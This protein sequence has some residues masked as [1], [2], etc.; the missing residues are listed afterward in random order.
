MLEELDLSENK[1]DE[2]ASL[3]LQ[4]WISKIG[5][6]GSLSKLNL[7]KTGAS[8]GLVLPALENLTK[9]EELDISNS[10]LDLDTAQI[11]SR[12]ISGSSTFKKLDVSSCNLAPSSIS[13]IIAAIVKNVNLRQVSLNLSD[14]PIDDSNINLL[15]GAF[16]SSRVIE[17]LDLSRIKLGEKGILQLFD[18]IIRNV[19]SLKTLIIQ[20]FFGSISGHISGALVGHSLAD[21]ILQIPSIKKLDIST[22]KH[23]MFTSPPAHV[24]LPFL[25]RMQR[26]ETLLELVMTGNRLADKLAVT[27]AEMLR[28][29]TKLVSLNI[30]DNKITLTGFQ[31]LEY[32]MQ[33]NRT[34]QKFEYPT[35]DVSRCV[36]SN[37]MSTEKLS[38][39][40]SILS[41]IHLAVSFNQSQGIHSYLQNMNEYVPPNSGPVQTYED[42]PVNTPTQPIAPS[43]SDW[44]QGPSTTTNYVQDTSYSQGGF[45]SGGGYETNTTSGGYDNSGYNNTDTT[46]NNYGYENTGSYENTGYEGQNGGFDGNNFSYESSNAPMDADAWNSYSYQQPDDNQSGGSNND[47]FNA[48]ASVL[49][50]PSS[51]S[52]DENSGAP[53]GRNDWQY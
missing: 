10:T 12:V 14:N 19:T 23:S 36:K 45:G 32:A 35:L 18:T 41:N 28:C 22:T 2:E 16:T 50:N 42:Q 47:L 27:I 5:A 39:L 40:F 53:Y 13:V 29:N 37:E 34:L 44:N 51:N 26:N 6:R 33:R 38:I 8:L 1:M 30:D 15:L 43:N 24:F 21:M 3:L 48:L 17:T 31:A 25:Q 52:F 7:R 46:Y 4:V 49:D 11:L 20:D 9:L